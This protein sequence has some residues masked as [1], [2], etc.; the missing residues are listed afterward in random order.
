[1]TNDRGGPSW[2]IKHAQCTATT[3]PWQITLADIRA[4]GHTDRML[5]RMT[6]SR[7]CIVCSFAESF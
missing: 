6:E 2:H 1:M 7:L 4:D 5:D 3:F